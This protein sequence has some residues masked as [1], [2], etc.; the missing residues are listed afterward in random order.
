MGG[1]PIGE[2]FSVPVLT[3]A[4]SDTGIAFANITSLVVEVTLILRDE[5]GMELDRLT[6]ELLPGE[7]LP[8]FATELFDHLAAGALFQGSIDMI[9]SDPISAVAL[10]QHGLLLT[11]FPILKPVL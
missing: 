10:K 9:A 2:R 3:A 8:R 7:H 11:T 6:L 5:S 4:G 1:A